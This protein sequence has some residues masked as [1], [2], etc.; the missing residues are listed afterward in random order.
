MHVNHHALGI[1]ITN[2]Q[3]ESFLQSQAQRIDGPE[4]SRVAMLRD[5]PDQPMHF[6]DGQHC[7]EG[8]LFGAA[9]ILEH[10]PLA[11]FGDGIEELDAAVRDAQR[12]VS[13]HSRGE[14]LVIDRILVADRELREDTLEFGFAV[15]ES[16]YHVWIKVI[17]AALDNDGLGD[18]RRIGVLVHSLCRQRV[19]DIRDGD[20]S[21]AKWNLGSLETAG[22]PVPSNLS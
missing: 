18:I 4:V 8:L 21:S 14:A 7:G 9:Q 1:E 17:T 15:Q 22:Y 16:L 3:V 6:V 11:W 2:L 19:V 20:D 13:V 12:T 5:G 10:V